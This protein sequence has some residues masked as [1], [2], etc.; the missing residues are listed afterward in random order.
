MNWEIAIDVF[1]NTSDNCIVGFCYKRNL[2][3]VFKF[4]GDLLWNVYVASY[5]K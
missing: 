1:G 5:S 3:T 2:Q 4:R